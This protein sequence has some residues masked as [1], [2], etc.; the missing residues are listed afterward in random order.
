MADYSIICGDVLARL[1]ELEASSVHCV[2]TSPPYWSLRDYQVDGQIGLELTMDE[3]IA[4]MVEV[5]AA[6]RTVLRDDGIVFINLGDSYANGTNDPKSFRRD[7][8]ECHVVG[9]QIPVGLKTKDLCGIPWRVALALQADGWWLRSDVIWA[10]PNPMP[11]FLR[12][13]RWERCRV[14]VSPGAVTRKGDPTISGERM[15]GHTH[16]KQAD[17]SPC[18]GCPKC[19]PNDGLVLRKGSWRPTCAHEYVFMLAKSADYWADG[20][21]VREAVLASSQD[22]CR[23]GFRTDYER[24]KHNRYGDGFMRSDGYELNRAGRNLRTVW[25]IPTQAYSAA[26]FATYPEKLVEP[27]IKAGTSDKGCCPECGSQWTRVV[28]TIKLTRERPNDRTSRHNAGDWVNSCGNT[29]AGVDT[30]TLGWRPSCECTMTRCISAFGNTGDQI[31]KDTSRVPLPARPS[32]VLDPFCGS[33]TTLLVACRLG[34]NAIGI[35]ISPDYCEMARKR[36]ERGLR[37][38]T[39]RDMT[40]TERVTLWH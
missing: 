31:I 5:F 1:G 38:S 7:K 22:R 2:V 23:H 10:K 4:K 3:Y 11:K 13:W 16:A 8:A 40:A 37:P 14:N 20:E 12:G 28:E 15:S 33:G 32:T 25:R 24:D 9:R 21:G 30:K 18:P 19:E 39:A 34:R 36:I 27:C 17:W 6:V 35:D 29:V 26:H